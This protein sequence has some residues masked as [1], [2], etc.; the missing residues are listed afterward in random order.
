MRLHLV[1]PELE[2][3]AAGRGV[4]VCWPG[5]GVGDA[6]TWTESIRNGR[7]GIENFAGRMRSAR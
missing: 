6:K 4:D 1:D 3:E 2:R 5:D 7:L